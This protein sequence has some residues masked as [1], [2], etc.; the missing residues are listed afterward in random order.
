MLLHEILNRN[1]APFKRYK[2]CDNFVKA[3]NQF[4]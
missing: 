2:N 1:Q 3:F 4:L